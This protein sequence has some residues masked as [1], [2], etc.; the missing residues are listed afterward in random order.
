MLNTYS[1]PCDMYTSCVQDISMIRCFYHKAETVSFFYE[2][3]VP[4]AVR[5]RRGSAAARPLRLWVRIPPGALIFVPCDCCVLSG[6]VSATSWSLVQG[7]PIDC[8]LSLC[9]I[10]K[11]E[12]GG[13]GPLGV[14]APKRC[15]LTGKY[16]QR[17]A[18]VFL[19]VTFH[20]FFPDQYRTRGPFE[21]LQILRGRRHI[22]DIES[23]ILSEK[24]SLYQVLKWL[25]LL[26]TLILP[27]WRIWLAP[28]NAS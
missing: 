18:S 17:A 10:W 16:V 15:I 25:K 27:T 12:W 23:L 24:I 7:R 3:T 26:L 6:G 22:V 5:S 28:N 14:V 2:H 4:A 9:V 21:I 11:H 13:L 8:G 1:V 19:M 20:G